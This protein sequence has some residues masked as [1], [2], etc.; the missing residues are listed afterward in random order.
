MLAA[1]LP[2]A[3]VTLV[4]SAGRKCEFIRAAASSMGVIVDV[5]H[6]R[7]EEVSGTWDVVTARALARLPVLCEYGAPLL[8]IG[9]ALVC[10]KGAVADDEAAAGRAAAA[11]VGLGEPEVVAVAPFP[12]SL[13]RTLWVFRKATV[14][15]GRYPRRPGMATKRPL[16][17]DSTSG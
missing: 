5:R 4:E 2:A 10:W 1:A 3:R 9:G 11:I 6:A 15:P 17:V 7:A 12:G 16:G 14:T 13:R 8:P